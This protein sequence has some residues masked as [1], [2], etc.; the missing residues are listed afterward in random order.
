MTAMEM[1]KKTDHLFENIDQDDE[2]FYNNMTLPTEDD[3]PYDDGEP[4]ETQRHRDQMNLL[5]DSLKA[6]W[7]D[8]RLYYIS[9][10]MFLHFDPLNKRKFRGPDVFL[11][12]DVDPRERKSWVVWQEGMRF[13]DLI[14]ELLSDATR[15]I[16]KGEKKTLY[17]QVFRTGEYYLYDPFSQEFKGYKLTGRHYTPVLPDQNYKIY[18]P[19]TE[20]FLIIH[21]E[22][23]R[24][25]TKDGMILPSTEELFEQ[26]KQRAE[27][28]KQRAEQEKQRAEQEK[29]RAEQEKQRA[30]QEKQRAEQAEGRL[31]TMARLMLAKGYSSQEV[32]E[33]TGLS[34]A[35]L[36]V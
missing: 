36:V 2:V 22:R 23:L 35:E 6:Y 29:Q 10:N 31:L 16:D 15:A 33:L 5:I 3:L 28:E 14:I 18:S 32:C 9:G 4:M 27:Q 26:E 20:L 34:E 21:D 25:M 12:L 17:E 13:P 8:R 30:E 1:I 11:V 7:K 24:W 19:I